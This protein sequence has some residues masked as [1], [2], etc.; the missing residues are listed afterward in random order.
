LICGINLKHYFL[1]FDNEGGFSLNKKEMSERDICSK[2]ITPALIQSGWD[3]LKQIR[4]E[5]TFTDGRVIVRKKMVSRGDKKRADYILFYKAN[6]PI[7][8]I[9][10]KDN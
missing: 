1:L 6:I 10:A 2:Y 3:L 5:V 8:I 7:A 9:E 4:E